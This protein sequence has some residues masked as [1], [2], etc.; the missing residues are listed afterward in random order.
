MRHY[1]LL[2]SVGLLACWGMASADTTITMA[3]SDGMTPEDTAIYITE[4]HMR[5][6]MDGSYMLFDPATSTMTVV[7]PAE[8]SYIVM[9]REWS[10][11]M[12]Q[13][14]KQAQA[15]MEQALTNLPPAQQERMREMIGKHFG[16]MGGEPK[17]EP[18]VM[19]TGKEKT[20]AGYSCEVVKLRAGT[21]ASGTYCLAS[22]TELGIPEADYQTLRDMIAFYKSIADQFAQRFASASLMGKLLDLGGIPIETHHSTMSGI[23]KNSM[24]TSV[25]IGPISADLFTIPEGYEK[26]TLPNDIHALRFTHDG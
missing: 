23:A 16:M 17:V 2:I 8:R 24:L 15:R 4:N 3:E 25:E 22:R 19:Q 20:V 5:T 13:M 26:L 1:K 12:E 14:M 18:E 6:G 21:I 10:A 11:S 7:Q 9:D